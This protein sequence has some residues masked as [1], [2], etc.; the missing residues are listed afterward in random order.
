MENIER[1]LEAFTWT[2]PPEWLKSQALLAA[3][4]EIIRQRTR[5]RLQTTLIAA[6]A[7]GLLL[8][9]VGHF[10]ANLI[11]PLRDNRP[12]VMQAG[13]V[14][15]LPGAIEILGGDGHHGRSVRAEDLPGEPA[16]QDSAA[17]AETGAGGR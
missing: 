3:Q 2:K 5:R 4:S 14:A 8:A 11:A 10:V 1:S 6:I 16:D 13:P 17:P 9:A 7:A 12:G 15:P